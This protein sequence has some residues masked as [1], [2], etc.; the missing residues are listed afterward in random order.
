MNSWRWKGILAV[1]TLGL[2]LSGRAL[3]EEHATE[4][5]LATLKGPYLFAYP[6][7]RT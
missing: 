5:S 2:A 3:A 6:I 7:S 4:C 1:V